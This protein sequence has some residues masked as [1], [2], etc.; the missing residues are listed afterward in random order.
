VIKLDKPSALA[1]VIASG[2][3][4]VTTNDGKLTAYGQR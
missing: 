1:P 3:L 4:L 2:M